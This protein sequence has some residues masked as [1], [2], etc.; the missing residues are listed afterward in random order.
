MTITL[1]TNRQVVKCARCKV[2]LTTFMAY[3][4]YEGDVCLKCFAEY[5]KE[6]ENEVPVKT[7]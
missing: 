4:P 3:I 7:A 1:S 6:H 5:A 2:A